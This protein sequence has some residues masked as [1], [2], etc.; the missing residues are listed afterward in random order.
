MRIDLKLVEKLIN[1][2]EQQMEQG[3]I[4]GD[5]SILKK[6]SKEHGYLLEVRDVAEKQ[7]KLEKQLAEVSQL[8][9]T[10]RDEEL[11]SLVSEEKVDLEASLA[12]V[13][14]SLQMLCIPPDPDDDRNTIM[15]IRAGAGGQEAALF[16]ADCARM[17]TMY[18]SSMKWNCER[19]S[20]MPSELGGLKECVL[21]FTGKGVWRALQHEAGT[22]RVQR[23]PE[24]EAQGRIH[25]STITVAVLQE[26][27]DSLDS[28]VIPESDLRMEATRASGAGGQHVNKT[29]S[30]VRVTHLPTGIAV[31]CQEERSQHK[32]KDRALKLLRSKIVELEKQK[33]KSEIDQKRQEQV[34]SGD[35]SEKIRTYNFP[36]SRVTDHRVN[37]TK[38]NLFQVLAGDLAEFSEALIRAAKMNKVSALPWVIQSE[39]ECDP[40]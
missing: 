33:Q 31:F 25:T 36:Q 15:E 10:E 24:T 23:V 35:R 8:L 3:A 29:D 30:A 1:D 19:I 2:I 22:H 21:V 11:L 5:P 14:Q 40:D 18:A 4:Q 39:N 28:L 9:K 7:E 6:L 16:V 26:V 20:S 34:G 37:I 38:Y 13:K 17:Y 12:K 27:D 32:N